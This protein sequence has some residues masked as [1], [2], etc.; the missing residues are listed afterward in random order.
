MQA[1]IVDLTLN[2]EIFFEKLLRVEEYAVL[3]MCGKRKNKWTQ[4]P[5]KTV[6]FELVMFKPPFFLLQNKWDFAL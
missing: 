2:R 5:V 1:N 6:Y 3:S 4:N